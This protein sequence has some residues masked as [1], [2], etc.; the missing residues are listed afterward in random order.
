MSGKI[1]FKKTPTLFSLIWSTLYTGEEVPYHKISHFLNIQEENTIQEKVYRTI[2]KYLIRQ[3]LVSHRDETTSR[4]KKSLAFWYNL[5]SSENQFTILCNLRDNLHN[6]LRYVIA[7]SKSETLKEF[8][9]YL[10]SKKLNYSEDKR[11]LIYISR[12]I[13]TKKRKRQLINW[14]ITSKTKN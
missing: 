5:L 6:L 10:L 14:R 9:E 1:T 2:H 12:V 13:E 4:Q 8:Y 3:K 7:I 11:N